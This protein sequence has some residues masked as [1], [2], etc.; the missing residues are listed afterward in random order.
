MRERMKT[1]AIALTAI[2]MAFVPGIAFCQGGPL[3]PSTGNNSSAGAVDETALRYYAATKDSARV[4][5]EIRRLKRLS[6]RWD[7]PADLWSTELGRGDEDDLWELFSADRLDELQVAIAAR[8]AVQPS[9]KPSRDLTDK[10][11]RKRYRDELMKVSKTGNWYEVSKLSGRLDARASAKDTE[12]MLTAAEGFARVGQFDQA[13]I[14]LGGALEGATQGQGRNAVVLRA[15]ALLPFLDAEKLLSKAKKG[16]N[17]ENEFDAIADDILWARISAILRDEG[18]VTITSEQL[19]R[20]SV[21][22]RESKE[23]NYSELLGWYALKT[24]A[25]DEAF[26]WFKFA[27]SRG[28]EAMVAHGLAQS[29]LRRGQLIESEEVAH[30]WRVPIANNSIFFTDILETKLT[31]EI[32]PEIAGERLTRYAKE[33][34]E[35][36]SGEGA[37]GLAWYSYNSCQYDKALEWFERAVAWHPKETTVYGYALALRRLKRAREFI[38]VVNRYDGLFPMLVGLVMEEPQTAPSP[39]DAPLTQQPMRSTPYNASQ[40]GVRGPEPMRNIPRPG[41]GNSAAATGNPFVRSGFPAAVNPANPLRFSVRGAPAPVGTVAAYGWRAERL[42]PKWPL[43]ARRVRGAVAMPYERF[44]YS[45]LPGIDGMDQ[46]EARSVAETPAA[47]GTLWSINSRINSA[48]ATTNAPANSV[49]LTLPR[50]MRS[51]HAP[52]R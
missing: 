6:P 24:G 19:A 36:Q 9:W 26:D 49:S 32:P 18:E 45:L 34:V 30:A 50:L 22:G 48:N 31:L 3:L 52:A 1:V 12:L 51:S 21:L 11:E 44:G 13:G 23:P 40:G 16:P 7:P 41:S 10:I 20:L 28:G 43:V 38:E 39:C 4:E 35:T 27:I 14:L 5:L 2:A 42:N 46:P 37:Q 29:L 8:T 47:L 25:A 33:T 15:F 17:G